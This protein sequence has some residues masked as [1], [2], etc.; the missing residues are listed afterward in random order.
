MTPSDSNPSPL[1]FS[2]AEKEEAGMIAA[3]RRAS[4]IGVKVLENQA[5]KEAPDR[6]AILVMAFGTTYSETRRKTIEAVEKDIH[7][8]YPE[9][10]IL[11]A[12]TS[13]IIIK[14]VHLKENVLKA[15]PARAFRKLKEEGYT[16]I[17][18][19]ALNIIPG[20]EYDYTCLFAES[21]L[22]MFKKIVISTPLLYFQG[23]KDQRDDVADLLEAMKGQFPPLDDGDAI[24][25]M[26]H[27]T[28]HPANAYYSVIQDRI[29]EM[30]L[31]PVFV[32]TVEG[33]PSL[34]DI[35]PPLKKQHIHHVTLMPTMLV[36]GDHAN[37][38]MAGDD[39]DSHKNILIREGFIVSTYIHGLGENEKVR[40]LYAARAIETM[41]ALLNKK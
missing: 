7:R 36:A 38:D 17:A 24:L 16:R 34:E 35:I 2:Q 30:G 23:V 14:R 4:S 20:I 1:T 39:P 32:Y 33:R 28:P 12:Y 31:G 22:S 19:V 8:L 26:A 13:K 40:R 5:M 3:L 9:I 18:V 6:D 29:R 10:P 37:N 11:E 21:Q 41:N 27:G 15:S 25:L